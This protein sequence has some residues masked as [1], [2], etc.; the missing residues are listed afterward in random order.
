MSITIIVLINGSK[1]KKDAQF[2][3]KMLM[4]IDNLISECFSEEN[5]NETFTISYLIYLPLT[6]LRYRYF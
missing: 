5:R 4:N 3:T 1:V 2:A 6:L